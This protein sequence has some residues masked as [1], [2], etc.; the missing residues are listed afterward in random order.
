[1]IDWS[2]G[3]VGTGVSGLDQD[4][5]QVAVTDANGCTAL[6][7]FTIVEP[8]ELTV[9][10]IVLTNETCEGNNGS[11][12]ANIMGGTPDYTILW[13]GSEEGNTLEQLSAGTYQVQVSDAM[14]CEASSSTTVEY[15]CEAQVPLTQLIPTDCGSSGRT[16]NEFVMCEPVEGASMYHWQ[17]RNPSTGLNFEG[18]S[19]GNNNTFL[20]EEVTGLGYHTFA[21]VKVR[22]QLGKMWGQFGE[23][24]VITMSETVPT[25]ALVEADCGIE[26]LVFGNSVLCNPIAGAYAYHWNV[27]GLAMDTTLITY[28]NELEL[29]ETAGFVEGEVYEVQVAAEVEDLLAPYGDA[30]N[31]TFDN[32]NSLEDL[33]Q[34]ATAMLI[35][36]NPNSGENISIEMWNLIE[37]LDVIELDVYDMSGK[38]VENIKLSPYGRTHFKQ[39]YRFKHQLAP[40]L[41]FIRHSNGDEVK[42]EK[43]I[44]R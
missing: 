39:D 30:C 4:S 7:E 38:L 18:Y 26:E 2:T 40:G 41:Y 16:L 21:E 36:P 27:S 3:D 13:N 42:E 24:C 32:T 37:G 43:L 11:V 23:A 8:S 20:L 19:I 33:D 10:A 14:G 6:E 12:V 15:D 44:V 25:T 29:Y 5:Y 35:Y 9:S 28:V 31:I 22:A 1:T 17:F 34:G